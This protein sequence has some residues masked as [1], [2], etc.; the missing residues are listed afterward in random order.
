MQYILHLL[1]AISHIL[2]LSSQQAYAI[3]SFSKKAR[4]YHASSQTAWVGLG[5][6]LSDDTLGGIGLSVASSS[7]GKIVAVGYPFAEN[8]AGLASVHKYDEDVKDWVEIGRLSGF[9][10]GNFLGRDVALSSNGSILA[11]SSPRA[12]GG[13]G[14]VGVYRYDIFTKDWVKIGD[15]ILGEVNSEEFGSSIALSD[16]GDLIAIGAPKAPNSPGRVRVYHFVSDQEPS[17][18]TIGDDIV[19]ESEND[20]AGSSVDIMEYSG[21]V[22][23]AVGAPM[24]LYTQGTAAVFQLNREMRSWKQLGGRYLDGNVPGAELGRSVSLGHDGTMLIVAVGFPGVGI[25]K[26]NGTKSGAQVYSITSGGNWGFYGERIYAKEEFDDT[27]YQ[28]SLSRDGQSLAVGSPEYGE[29]NGLVRLY[30]KGKE[31]DFFEQIG[32]DLIG[33]KYDGIGI[34]VAL[35]SSGETVSVGSP[36][37]GYVSIFT[38]D[39]SS[40]RSHKYS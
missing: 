20:E 18:T 33:K 24:D 17:W 22:F 21:D 10:H 14:L 9:D 7:N 32:D 40:V 31:N 6:P 35:S 12:N 25:D 11:V 8:N 3:P 28:V 27:G 36:E 13:K 2:L 16:D 34:S 29:G 39:R 38:V 4:G 30:F 15:D 26:D 23:V 19:G 5:S 37:G 1:V